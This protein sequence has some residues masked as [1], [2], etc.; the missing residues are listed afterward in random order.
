[1]SDYAFGPFS[2][3]VDQLLERVREIVHEAVS[4]SQ[5]PAEP[6][7]WLNVKSAAKYLDMT[8]DALRS[9]VKR[10][11]IKPYR[12]ENNGL[13]FRREQLDAFA[14]GEAE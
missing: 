10:G 4:A 14:M 8:E 13:R 7:P 11:E 9:L 12:S 2:T 6:E 1:M 3:A 5:P